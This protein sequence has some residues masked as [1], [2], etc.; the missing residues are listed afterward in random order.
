[1]QYIIDIIALILHGETKLIYIKIR[2][3]EGTIQGL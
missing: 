1:M 3:N 2:S